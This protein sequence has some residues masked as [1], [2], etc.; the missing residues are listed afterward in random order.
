MSDV[1]VMD[2]KLQRIAAEGSDSEPDDASIDRALDQI[3]LTTDDIARRRAELCLL[4]SR[5]GRLQRQNAELDSRWLE[6]AHRR[7]SVSVQDTNGLDEPNEPIGTLRT[8]DIPD[9]PA[10]KP[11][12]A[13]ERPSAAADRKDR[14]PRRGIRAV[15]ARAR[16]VQSADQESA[17]PESPAPRTN[18]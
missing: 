17:E 15:F 2:D 6:I 12:I 3:A 10:T 1:E 9:L 7:A 18:S 5:V 14:P 4:E 13:P 8:I 11:R 16:K